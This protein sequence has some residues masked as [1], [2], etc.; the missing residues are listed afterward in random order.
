MSGK[1]THALH[2]ALGL[3]AG[4]AL[5]FL[6]VRSADPGKLWERLTGVDPR[7]FVPFFFLIMALLAAF[8]WLKAVRWSRLLRPLAPLRA[9]DV[10]P[11]LMIGFMANNLLPAHLGEF[12]R[13]YVLA[14][15]RGLSNAAVL[16]TIVLERLMDFLAIVAVFA[17]TLQFVPLSPELAGLRAVGAVVGAATL[18]LFACFAAF[19]WRTA[20]ALRAAD[21][22]LAAALRPAVGALIFLP[23]ERRRGLSARLHARLYGLLQAGV[24]G[25]FS[26]RDPLQF[27]AMLG[28]T[29]LIWSLNGLMLYL[30]AVS[31][32]PAEFPSLLAAFFLFSVCALGITLPSAPGYIG[33]TQFC[34]VIALQPFGVDREVA[35]AGSFYALFLGIVPV[36]LAGLFF[37]ARLGLKLRTLKEEATKAAESGRASP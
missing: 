37:T 34:F 4:G 15:Q 36:T 2:T 27:A 16:S 23:R 35:L 17:V 20:W 8:F 3:A 1:R 19:V 32:T 33:T 11:S 22:F 21:R 29:L 5:L 6:A 24:P 10:L 18:V 13:M 9:N 14:A 31:F 26:L 25:L 7:F 12:V 30:A 28:M